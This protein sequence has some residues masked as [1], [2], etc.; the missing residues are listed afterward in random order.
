MDAIPREFEEMEGGI[1]S[2]LGKAP[3]LVR[4]LE[5]ECMHSSDGFIYEDNELFYVTGCRLCG[6]QY[7]VSKSSGLII[8]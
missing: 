4:A 1:A 2:L 5:P 7:K 8:D 3:K 6:L